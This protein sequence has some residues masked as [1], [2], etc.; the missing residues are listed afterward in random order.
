MKTIALSP[1]RYTSECPMQ[2]ANRGPLGALRAD[3][4][5]LANWSLEQI[6]EAWSSFS[7]DLYL[8]GYL[9]LPDGG[10][11]TEFIA[12][13]YAVQTGPL[14]KQPGEALDQVRAI[15]AQLELR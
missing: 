2:E 4:P 11:T 14:S 13:I 7:T 10:R 9:S 1:D 12:Y 8:A 5:E 15:E 3:N 6:D